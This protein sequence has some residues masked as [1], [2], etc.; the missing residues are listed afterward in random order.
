MIAP[1]LPPLV[2]FLTREVLLGADRVIGSRR[3]AG[4]QERGVRKRPGRQQR[5]LFH[6][7]GRHAADP[8]YG[9]PRM[10]RGPR[11]LAGRQEDRLHE[12]RRWQ[13]RHIRDE[14]GRHQTKRACRWSRG[15]PRTAQAPTDPTGG[16]EFL[17]FCATLGSSRTGRY[18]RGTVRSP[19]HPKPPAIFVF[20]RLCELRIH[21]VPRNW[22]SGGSPKPKASGLTPRGRPAHRSNS[23]PTKRL[24]P[25]STS[26]IVPSS[27]IS[28]SGSRAT[29]PTS[30]QGPK[31]T[32]TSSPAQ[33][34]LA[35]HPLLS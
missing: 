2:R 23:C 32:E 28:G 30:A 5:D 9:R 14:R 4:W 1:A 26:P 24:R 35:R 29:P 10:G 33:L 15:A 21:S 18:R 17:C 19:N 6:E 25:T 16:G 7:V 3:L 34:S 12:V 20:S 22:P 31:S 27:S 8:P 13:Q 11:L